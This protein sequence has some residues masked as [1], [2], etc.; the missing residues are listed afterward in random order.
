MSL[1]QFDIERFRR[2]FGTGADVLVTTHIHPDPDAVGSLLA[3]REILLRLG[4]SPHPVMHDPVPERCRILPGSDFVVAQTRTPMRRQFHRAVILDAGSLERIGAVQELIAPGAVTV[5]FDH[6]LSN[7]GF[8][9]L[10]VVD[11]GYAATAELLFELCGALAIPL[12]PNLANNLFA[13]LLTD[14]GRFRYTNTTARTL[15]IASELAATGAEITRITNGMYFDIAPEDIRAMGRIYSSLRLYDD[16]RISTLLAPLDS[17]VEDP[18]S[19]VDLA[20][21][22]RGVHVAALLSE[23]REDKI[24]VSLRARHSV[25]VARIA[26]SFG[27]GGHEKAAGFRM[28]GTLE[29]VR[30]TL[31]PALLRALDAPSRNAAPEAVCTRT[32]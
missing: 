13:G 27:G 17:L 10:N 26:E 23:T 22:I 2:E 18:D 32:G 9:T 5:N 21:S 28:R 1:A 15:R 29:S 20:L 3:M 25:N 7:D 30:D 8:G 16:G 6:H 31:L 4:A 11:C 12:T 24:R 14:T 19:I